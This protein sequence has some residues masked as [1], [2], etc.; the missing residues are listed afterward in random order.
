MNNSIENQNEQIK[1]HLLAGK[2]VSGLFAMKRFGCMRLS[3]RIWELRNEHNMNIEG[4]MV[5]HNGKSFKRYFLNPGH[6]S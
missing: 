2:G 1:A 6:S 5:K 3:A 4:E